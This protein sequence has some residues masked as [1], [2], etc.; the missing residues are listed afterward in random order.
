MMLV[1]AWTLL[2]ACDGAP[3]ARRSEPEA[4]PAA[5]VGSYEL[6]LCATAECGPASQAPGSR[7]GRLQLTSDR[8]AMT[9]TDSSIS[10]HGCVT[11]GPQVK[12]DAATTFN[13]IRWHQGQTAGRVIFDMVES[14]TAEYEITLDDLGGIMRGEGR[15]RRDGIISEEAPEY[16]VARRKP[17]QDKILCAAAVAEPAAAVAT[18]KR[19]AKGT[20]VAA[21]KKK[22]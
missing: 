11:V 16:V 2:A 5:L 20:P 3:E 22:G 7:I 9:M 13:A 8:V 10:Y 17:V 1:G 18:A 14:P 21:P 6:W 4:S 15:W 19:A 12:V